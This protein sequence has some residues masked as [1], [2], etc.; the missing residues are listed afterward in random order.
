MRN[1]I[2]KVILIGLFAMPLF[3]C[4]GEIKH[5]KKENVKIYG[6]CSMCKETIEEA[7][8]K[9]KEAKAVW[10]ID[11]KIA[12]IIYDSTKT[13]LNTILLRIA[14]TGYDSDEFLATDES[15]NNL[16]KCCKYDR[17]SE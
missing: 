16:H 10:N 14:Q 5:T 3:G 13:N 12:I 1:L 9:N 7:A 2:I 6:N 11:S 8:F 17:K 4:D 15:Y